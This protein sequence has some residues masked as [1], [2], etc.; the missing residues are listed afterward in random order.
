MARTNRLQMYVLQ[1]RQ[2]TYQRSLLPRQL[3]SY[4]SIRG[5]DP[6]GLTRYLQLIGMRV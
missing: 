3:Q 4:K 6:T 2:S 5:F 1:N